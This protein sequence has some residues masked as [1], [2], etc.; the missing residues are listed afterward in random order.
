MDRIKEEIQEYELLENVLRLAE[1]LKQ[2]I[3]LRKEKEKFRLKAAYYKAL[4]QGSSVLAN[5]I[6]E[7][8]K[9]NEDYET[10]AFDGF[11]YSSKRA[12]ATYRTLDDMYKTNLITENEFKLLKEVEL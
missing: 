12:N 6:R 2:N 8:I 4:F 7:Q 11:A 10:G 1:T 5:K 9:E 3:Y